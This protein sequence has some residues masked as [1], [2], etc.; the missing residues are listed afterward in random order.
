MITLCMLSIKLSK[1]DKHVSK[2]CWL[3]RK[4]LVF[5]GFY[6]IF[7][8]CFEKNPQNVPCVF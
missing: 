6:A 2:F 5:S 1:V 7:T 4:K 8:K 3:G